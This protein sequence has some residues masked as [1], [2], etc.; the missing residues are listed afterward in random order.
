MH[1]GIWGPLGVYGFVDSAPPVNS[2]PHEA[3]VTNWNAF[4]NGGR[5]SLTMER[6][7]QLVLSRAESMNPSLSLS[8]SLSIHP[9]LHLL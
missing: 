8:I 2:R 4:Q 9:F 3:V 1:D 7:E 5:N 6:G